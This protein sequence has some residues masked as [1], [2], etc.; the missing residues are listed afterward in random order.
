MPI[1]TPLKNVK[2][3]PWVGPQRTLMDVPEGVLTITHFTTHFTRDSESDSKALLI[4]MREGSRS[5]ALNGVDWGNAAYFSIPDTLPEGLSAPGNALAPKTVVLGDIP[6]RRVFMA[7]SV[8]NTY[9]R[10]LW[11]KAGSKIYYYDQ[12]YIADLPSYKDFDVIDSELAKQLDLWAP[13]DSWHPD[14]IFY[15]TDWEVQTA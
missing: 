11:F 8:R 2:I 14:Q 5:V 10:I 6:D 4:R 13:T 1:Q 15:V 9:C 7:N 3:G 12:R